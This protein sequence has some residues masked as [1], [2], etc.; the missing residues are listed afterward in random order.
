M[1]VAAGEDCHQRRRDLQRVLDEEFG[2]EHTTLQ[3]DHTAEPGQ[4]LSIEPPR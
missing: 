2:V 1:I 3:V 4:L